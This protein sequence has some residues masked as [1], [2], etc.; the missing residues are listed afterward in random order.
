[1]ILNLIS[2]PRNVSTALMYSFANRKDMFA[3]D[4][5][6]YAYYLEK[7]GALH[8]GREEII[9]SQKSDYS[10]VVKEI[11]IA[12]GSNDHIFIKNMAHHLI[13]MDLDFISN[14]C[15]IILIRNP[16]QLIAS[17]AQVIKNPKQ[18]DIGIKRQ[19][20]IVQFLKS[21]NHEFH[22]LDSGILLE[23]PEKILSIL[24]RKVGIPMSSK[25]LSWTPHQCSQ[26]GIWAKYWYTNVHQS[27][28][29][30]KQPTSSR[31]LPEDCVTLYEESKKYYNELISLA[32]K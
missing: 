9:S 6:F 19:F 11:E 10:E 31:R 22:I 27:S 32:I 30:S 28:G 2:S 24:C 14:W 21:Q 8:P 16:K 13:D 18:A 5:P 17:F 1:M 29:F 25:M 26:D 12:G 3:V 23:N 20:E 4:E 7:T 15:N